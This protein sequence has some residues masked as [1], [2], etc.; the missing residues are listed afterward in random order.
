M[1]PGDKTHRVWSVDVFRG[2]TVS[3]MILVNNPGSWQ[4]IYAPL[5]HAKWDGLTLADLVFPFFLWVMGVSH[6]LSTSGK[7]GSGIRIV[8]RS[9]ILFSIGL[10]FNFIPDFDISS[11]RIPGVLQRIAVCYLLSS[12]LSRRGVSAEIIGVVACLGS[13]AGLMLAYPVPDVGPGH[14]EVEQNAARS[15]DARIL[16]GHMWSVTKT[17]DPEGIVSTLPAVATTL[18]GS[19]A[20][21]WIRAQGIELRYAVVLPAAGVVG[22]T[23]GALVSLAFPVNKNLWSPSYVFV[24]V[25]GACILLGLGLLWES[26]PAFRPTIGGIFVRSLAAQ[27]KNPLLLYVISVFA[28]KAAAYIKPGGVPLREYAFQFFCNFFPPLEASLVYALSFVIV[29]AA[30]GLWLEKRSVFVRL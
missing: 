17:W 5:R 20:G 27:G 18:L 10:L 28:G 22:I 30:L 3:L 4:A 1:L 19:M 24:T 6:A 14:L 12:L 7:G 13:Y 16:A 8:R 2:L 26:R 21:R 25:G 15:I 9:L 29:F 11:V 23:A